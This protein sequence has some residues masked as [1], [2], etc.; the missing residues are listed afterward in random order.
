MK[1]P[2]LVGA[3]AYA[4]ASVILVKTI[5]IAKVLLL[6][7]ARNLAAGSVHWAGG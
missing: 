4:G 2:G 3:G 5:E 1:P 6:L 7:R